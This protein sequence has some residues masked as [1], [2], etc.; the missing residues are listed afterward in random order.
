MK[1][2]VVI[3]FLGSTLDGSKLDASR[4]NKWR[5]SVSLVMHEDLRVDRF[6]L[7][8]GTPHRGLA[9]F[10]AE[11]IRSVSPETQ[12]D[13]YLIDFAD[14]WDFEEVYGKLLD[15]VRASPFDPEVEDYLVHITTGTHVAQ[16]CLFLLTEAHYL[17]GRL[18]QTQPRRGTAEPAGTWNAIDLD[19]S[20]YDSIATRF[21]VASAES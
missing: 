18:L 12:V 17:P 9:E 21:S 20:R 3:G 4:W 15:F 16:I 10:V 13:P 11:D 1:P 8:H 14:A 2:L 5:P 6:V 7:L 19:L